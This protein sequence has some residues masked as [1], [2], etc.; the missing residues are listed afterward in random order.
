MRRLHHGLL[1][2]PVGAPRNDG[3]V[4]FFVKFARRFV[5]SRQ[6]LS[7]LVKRCQG[8]SWPSRAISRA[9]DAKV[10]KSSLVE[11]LASADGPPSP[12]PTPRRTKEEDSATSDIRKAFVGFDFSPIA[13]EVRMTATRTYFPNRVS[14]S[15]Q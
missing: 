7:S 4:K 13:P 8:F 5:K 15:L 10:D 12:A 9:Y 11:I 1:R 6:V 3:A 14:P 2:R